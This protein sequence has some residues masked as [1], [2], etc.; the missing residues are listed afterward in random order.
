MGQYYILYWPIVFQW[1]FDDFHWLCEVY[2]TCGQYDLSIH[3]FPGAL[4]YDEILKHSLNNHCHCSW[5]Y[6][7][8]ST[9]CIVDCRFDMNTKVFHNRY[10]QTCSYWSRLI[11]NTINSNLNPYLIRALLM[12]QYPKYVLLLPFH[13]WVHRWCN[14]LIM[15]PEN[16]LNRCLSVQSILANFIN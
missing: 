10:G 5:Q 13:R 1:V 8:I 12:C 3:R 4:V 7:V 15:V 14:A 9:I 11:Q 2:A 6:A 16:R